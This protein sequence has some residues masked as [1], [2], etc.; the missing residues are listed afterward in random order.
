VAPSLD[1]S[2][3]KQILRLADLALSIED[4]RP[5]DLEL[6]FNLGFLWLSQSACVRMGFA[7]VLGCGW[8]IH[9][10]ASTLRENNPGTHHPARAADEDEIEN[11]DGNSRENPNHWLSIRRGYRSDELDFG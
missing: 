8:P 4:T 9:F 3:P 1:Q 2:P 7:E 11:Y 5:L 6:G 10:A